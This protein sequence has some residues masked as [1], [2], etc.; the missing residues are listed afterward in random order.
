MR[1]RYKAD[2]LPPRG[3]GAFAPTMGVDP[4]ASS[5]GLVEVAGA[6]GNMPVFSPQPG[7]VPVCSANQLTSPSNVAP[8]LILP[9][10]YVTTPANMHGPVPHRP[11]NLMPA[12][13]ID[14][15]RVPRN[16]LR[17]PPRLGG[18]K[19]IPWPRSFQRWGSETSTPA[20]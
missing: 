8:D 19:V 6:P 10:V 15:R 9:A 2:N 14:Y 18:R 13:A 1:W 12:P 4:V 17:P 7:A 5:Y 20:S 3:V 16:A 11:V